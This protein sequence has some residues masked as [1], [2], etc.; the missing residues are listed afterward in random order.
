MTTG[1]GLRAPDVVARVLNHKNQ[2]DSLKVIGLLYRADS[3]VSD[4][5]PLPKSQM[6]KLGGRLNTVNQSLRK[7]LLNM[8]PGS[9]LNKINN[10]V[11]T[12]VMSR[13]EG[14]Q[15][16]GDSFRL[17]M[18]TVYQACQQFGQSFSVDTFGNGSNR[19][20]KPN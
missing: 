3:D 19:K 2:E 18:L 10:K 17:F 20:I 15:S 1:T 11:I 7:I 8:I 12:Q 5:R 13:S 9:I 6:S 14:N 4:I 16:T